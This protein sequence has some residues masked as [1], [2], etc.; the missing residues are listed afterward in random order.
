MSFKDNDEE[1]ETHSKSDNI[2]MLINDKENEVIEELFK[3]LLSRYQIGLETSLKGNDFIFDCIYLFYYK[4]HKTKFK[5]NN[6][7][8]KSKIKLHQ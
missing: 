1:R 8:K 6:K 5:R 2:E 7:R 4:C 3:S